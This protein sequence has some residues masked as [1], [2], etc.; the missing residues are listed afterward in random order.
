MIFFLH[1]LYIQIKINSTT[2]PTIAKP[3]YTQSEN[4]P[5]SQLMTSYML[6]IDQY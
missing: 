1:S 5:Q 6:S 3:T 2:S 4:V